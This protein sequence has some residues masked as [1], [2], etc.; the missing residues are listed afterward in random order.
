MPSGAAPQPRRSCP[1]NEAVPACTNWPSVGTRQSG[2][3]H[4]LRFGRPRAAQ[5]PAPDRDYL[6]AKEKNREQALSPKRA[7][8][9]L[10][11]LQLRRPA[12]PGSPGR[13]D[14]ETI[15]GHPAPAYGLSR[16]LS[17]RWLRIPPQRVLNNPRAEA[18]RLEFI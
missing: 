2:W 17:A 7:F 14:D 13:G 5:Q 16:H 15:A 9:P 18:T 6:L 8:P 12:R 4:A 3:R 1:R 10:R 11:P